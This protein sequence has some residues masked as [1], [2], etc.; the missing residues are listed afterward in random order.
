[1]F[2]KIRRPW[3]SYG[4]I[5][6]G[7]LLASCRS[8]SEDVTSYELPGSDFYP[9]GIARTRDGTLFV[10]SLTSG[11]IVRLGPGKR[12]AEVFVPSGE[13]G[14]RAVVSAAGM[15]A[16]EER[17]I[18][19]VCD[20]AM[21][22]PLT[23]GVVGIALNDGHVAARHPFPAPKGLCN[24]VALDDEGNLYA[25]DSYVPRIFRIAAGA[26]LADGPATEW[27][28]DPRWAVEPGQ[29]GLN[30]VVWANGNVYVAHTQNNAL[31]RIPVG[32]G[33]T[34]GVATALTL[35][36]TPNGLDGLKVAADGSLVFVE[37]FANQLVRVALPG[38]DTG[39]LTVLAHG[40]NEPTTF[41]L[42]DGG[43]WIVE[44]QLLHLFGL[45]STPPHLP[46][47][48]VWRSF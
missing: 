39:K 40:L 29:F 15:L 1:M 32:T 20:S 14:Q 19:W 45:E 38:D 10:G 44:G 34:A 11:S 27:A 33:G 35:D 26:K 47:R 28:T 5:L 7:G 46:F 42:L 8:A 9:E 37:G 17:G 21:G 24:D 2:E 41:A 4:V 48:V 23:S 12:Q 25:T 36:R 6:L 31:Y 13:V 16:D 18:L 22:A 3:F 43:A 30:G